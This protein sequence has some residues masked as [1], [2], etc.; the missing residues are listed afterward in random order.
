MP[1]SEPPRYAN[2]TARMMEITSTRA[3]WHR[4]LWRSG[5]MQIA[6]ELLD[7]SVRPGAPEAAITD[8]RSYVMHCL[9]TDHGIADHGKCVEGTIKGITPGITES[10]HAW[11]NL[12]EHIDRMYDSYLVNW[13][14]S[15]DTPT[16]NGKPIDV[17][18]AARRITAHLLDAGMHKS[19][20]YAWLRAIRDDDSTAITIGDFLREADRRL[21]QPERIYTFCVPV[22]KVGGFDVATAPG[23]M[24]A[25]QTA[26]WKRVHAQK[27][28]G[29]LQRGSFLLDVQAR[30][31]NAAADKARSRISNLSAK[32]Y[33]GSS[34]PIVICP[35][36]WSKEKGSEFP[37]HATNRVINVRS[38]ELL[39]RVQDLEMLDY[40][41]NTLALVQ[42]LR[43]AA[44]HI[45]VM[46]GWSAIESLMV[47]PSDG[48]DAIAAKRFSLIVAASMVRAELSWLSRT[49]ATTHDDT[50]A[51]EMDKCERNIDRARLFQMHARANPQI[52][53]QKSVDNLA[54]ERIRP[55]LTDPRQEIEKISGIL[56]REFTRL[57]RKRNMI[58]HGGHT[59]ESNLHSISETL[60]P[61]IGAGI[62][63]VVHVG[64]TFNVRPI[65]LSAVAESRVH[66]L[67]PATDTN[68][69]NLLDLLEF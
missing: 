10:S 51:A 18:G 54:L 58:V 40:I 52:D 60:A 41:T 11:I 62:D 25:Q 33:L 57:Y 13:A 16:P 9:R 21:R 69:G 42:P 36:M 47:G 66:Y 8:Q 28:Q 45:A 2:F 19:S 43:T 15:L 14:D 30:D 56:T 65:E 37:T 29:L 31:V 32:F 5:T 68:P 7:E 26:Q 34:T 53:L 4:R 63:R 12:R 17:E 64:L 38:F 44:P 3:P 49:Y 22:E 23:W 1:I 61:L 50:A 67:V 48:Q 59:Q 20:L 39:G 6:R 46:S 27:A 35:S 24:T 55:A